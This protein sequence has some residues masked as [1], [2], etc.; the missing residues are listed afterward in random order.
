MIDQKKLEQNTL[1]LENRK[2]L[3]LTGVESVDSFSEQCLKLTVSGSR[4]V[5]TGENIK[6]IAFN[7]E[8][9]NLTAEGVINEIKYLGKQVAF[10]KR[11]FK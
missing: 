3:S 11:I 2:S 8:S 9:G 7:K 6:I 10:L 4:V 5:V 1:C